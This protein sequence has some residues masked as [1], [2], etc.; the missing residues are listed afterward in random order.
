[1]KGLERPARR[2]TQTD[3]VGDDVVQFVDRNDTFCYKINTFAEDCPLK[4]VSNKA[5]DLLVYD[6]GH[7][8]QRGI[9]RNSILHSLLVGLLTW[10]DLHQWNQMR[11]VEGMSDQETLRVL[12]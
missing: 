11:W 2:P 5:S 8:A 10:N 7:L 9:E 4:P 1:M 6:L 12:H 3:R